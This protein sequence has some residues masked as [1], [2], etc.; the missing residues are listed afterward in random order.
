[1]LAH[2]GF[3]PVRH[4][5]PLMTR[6]IEHALNLCPGELRR[7]IPLFAYLFLVMASYVTGRVARD[8]LFLSRFPAVQLPYVDIATAFA[9]GVVIAVYISVGRRCGLRNLL[10]GSLVLFASN[11]LLLWVLA[12]FQP[13]S[14]LYPTIYV[15]VGIFG[16]LAT[17]QVWA[18]VNHV[19]TT[20][21]AR[22]VFGLV[23]GGAIAGGI[24]A[25]FFSRLAAKAFGTE[26]LLLGMAI[27]LSAC[28]LLV[29]IIWRQHQEGVAGTEPAEVIAEPGPQNLLHSV[30]LVFSSA[31]L[32]AIAAVIWTSSFVT[33]L[34]G[35]QFKA[36]AKEFIPGK[37][38]LA[39]FFGDF[40]FYA[41][42]LALLVQ[43][44]LTSRLLR[45][46]GI[47]LA[48][49]TLPV[50]LLATSAYML[51]A[52]TLFAAVLLRGSDWVW[53]YSID[54][55]T[56]ELLYLPLP[57]PVKFQVKWFIDTVIWRMGDGLA[58]LTVLLFAAYLR[59]T[60]RQMSWVGLVLVGGWLTAVWVARRQYLT[61]L[62]ASMRE[63]RLDA[64]HAVAPVLDRSTTEVLA[65]NL[66]SSDPSD[67]LYAL[68][69]F[70]SGR[71]QASHPAIRDLL[72]HPAPEVRK[73]AI[74]I[75]AAARDKTVLPQMERLLQDASLDVRT[76][77][78]LYLA[79]YAH[80]DPLERIQ[81]L[82]DFADFSIRSAMAAFLARP[83]E[84]QNLEAARQLLAAMVAEAG[85]EGTRTR[86]EAARLLGMLPDDFGP[87]LSQLLADPDLEVVRQAIRS[88]GQLRKRRLAPELLDHLADPP[89]VP[90][91]TDA[92]ARFGDSIVGTLRDH[93]TDPTTSRTVRCEIPTVL[94]NMGTQSA[95]HAL[96][97]HL[98]DSD[99]NFRLRI[100]SASNNLHRR[101]PELKCDTQ[102][103]ETALA[104]EIL[105]HYR[106]Y[107]ILVKLD[108]LPENDQA[109]SRALSESMKLEIERVFRLLELLYPY[110]DFST[111]YIGLQSK[112]IT[113]H[114]NALEFLD[115]V[116]KGQ[117]RA[118]LVPLL[119]G[120]VTSAERASIADRLVPVR[121]ENSKQAA[122]ALVAS[123][124]PWLRSCGAYAIGTLGLNS[125][126]DDLNRCLTD[127]DPLVRE[128][129]RLAKLRLE[130]TRAA[131]A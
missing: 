49:F 103:L 22:R 108:K 79:H 105:G 64:D 3:V 36:I 56:V 83:G 6:S 37:D 47:G 89:L 76:E 15:W 60:A 128:T 88:V 68:G 106:S 67:I 96:M 127:P 43:L 18:L 19:L 2:A 126:F 78:L 63:H 87:L 82:G 91:I 99:A 118:I 80:V 81:E 33:A 72:N 116:L 7:G 125:L 113:V 9:V 25:G 122:A 13:A 70:E 44:L 123:D 26:S 131:S 86:M 29:V 1:M 54:K 42:I 50:A 102:M 24:F 69:L 95:S 115:S 100:L 30:K 71:Q 10:L 119:D 114:D 93:M 27:F 107:Q 52:G 48:L 28:P 17:T 73:K 12:R 32:R 51:V 130:A 40:T 109:L 55:S 31:Y 84:T 75:L 124:D 85:P 104:A 90:D 121:I 35:W 21:E 4:G 45:R 92:L 61:T 11:C 62:T 14:W 66:S 112:S 98:L 129:A 65:A 20:R 74:S 46:F 8:S 94:G 97:E 23:A 59:L 57:S 111:A 101:H 41:G 39:A 120:K 5:N 34:I 58:G 53:R 110:R 77:A 117:L 38:H 16:V